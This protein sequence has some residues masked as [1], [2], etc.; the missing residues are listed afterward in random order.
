MN[1]AVEAATF[2]GPWVWAVPPERLR[3]V[4][5]ARASQREPERQAVAQREERCAWKQPRG[6]QVSARQRL[7]HQ[8]PE[9]LASAPQR[10]RPQ[11]GLLPLEVQP[12]VSQ[13]PQA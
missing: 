12:P 7:A 6:S 4:L 2:R 1:A 9:H 5:Q 3:S 8:R 10:A 13:Q 11:L